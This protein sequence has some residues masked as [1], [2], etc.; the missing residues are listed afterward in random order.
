MNIIRELANESPK[1]LL[2]HYTDAE[3]FL[4]IFNENSIWASSAYHLNDAKEFRYATDLIIERVRARL[5][6]ERGPNN[7]EYARLI[8]AMQE[9]HKYVQVFVSSFSEEGDLL[10][11][12]LAYSGSTN[13]YAIGFSCSHFALAKERGFKL[14]RCVYDEESQSRLVDAV[15]DLFAQNGRLYGD[16]EQEIIRLILTAAAAMKHPGFQREIEWRLVKSQVIQL[17]HDEVLFRSGRNGI[18]PYLK[19]PL[20][21]EDAEFIPESIYVGP[22]SDIGTAE[23][24]MESFAN[25]DIYLTPPNTM[26]CGLTRVANGIG[27][28][29]MDCW[30][31]R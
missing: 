1:N 12:W 9:A 3:G 4:G 15:I 13:G 21:A 27:S 24:A 29:C 14:V 22:N 10:S 23:T 5:K 17:E 20:A 7:E 30:A 19:I 16:E 26:G 6:S 8:D 2:F 31:R 25:R 11:Q 18:V 28:V